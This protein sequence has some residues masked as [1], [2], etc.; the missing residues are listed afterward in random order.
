MYLPNVIFP[1]YISI[2]PYVLW[3]GAINL[4]VLLA[5]TWRFSEILFYMYLLSSDHLI[6]NLSRRQYQVFCLVEKEIQLKSVE[7]LSDII[8]NSVVGD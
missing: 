8:I 2:H 6:G 1:W 7:K 5:S 3:T 4:I